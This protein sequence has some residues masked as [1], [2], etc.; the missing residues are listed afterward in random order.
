MVDQADTM[1]RVLELGLALREYPILGD[2]I[3]RRMR[4]EMF[5]RGVVQPEQFEQEVYQKAVATQHREGLG[6]PDAP[7]LEDVWQMRLARVRD[8]LTEFYFANNL[9]RSLF[10]AVVAGVL[11]ERNQKNVMLQ[12]NP[13]TAPPSMLLAQASAFEEADEETR[14]RTEHHR[15]EVIVV[16][17]KAMLSDQLAFVARAKD[18]LRVADLKEIHARRIGRGKVGGKAAGLRLAARILQTPSPDDEVDLSSRVVV[19][20]TWHI[21]AD[22][23]YEFIE[24]NDLYELFGQKY[25]PLEE[26]RADHE[27]NQARFAASRL[28]QELVRKLDHI[29]DQVGD[30]P[31]IARSSSLLE[32][33]FGTAFAGKYE[34]YFCPNQGTRADRLRGLCDAIRKVYASVLNPDALAY[35]KQMGLIDYDERMAILLQKVE[36]RVWRRL[37][38][39]QVAGVGFSRNP[40][41]WTPRIDRSAGFLRIVWG[42]GTRAVNRVERDHPRLVA[43]SHPTLRPERTAREIQ[44][45]SQHFVD[46]I[47]LDKNAFVSV[48]VEDA[49]GCD[50]PS[51][52][53]IA[54]VM[55][56]GELRR[57]LLADPRTPA[58]HYVVTFD[59]M[60]QDALFP[61]VMRAILR[62]LEHAYGVPVDIEFTVEILPGPV[63]DYR[64]HLLQCRPQARGKEDEHVHAPRD[65]PRGDLVFQSAHTVTS[66]R[67]SNIRHV[68]FVDPE[69]YSRI[70]SMHE[71]TRLARLIG[72]INERLAGSP[73]VLVGPGRWGS[74]NAELGVP[75]TYADIYNADALVEVP[76]SIQDEEPEASFG[77]H[78]FQDLVES[79]IKPVAVYPE[80]GDHFDFDFFRRAPNSLS[81]LLADT[82]GLDD[83]VRVIDVPACQRG[84]VLEMVLEAG[85]EELAVAFLTDAPG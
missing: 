38:F 50:Y 23:N 12:L 9:P 67:V 8:M 65:V 2:V 6:E 14:R 77:T 32:D 29:L 46:A 40:Y 5:R 42:L 37:F 21:A 15:K 75:V 80:K 48:P 39:P 34:T 68:V 64:V 20:E 70:P 16:L 3:R 10:Q 24:E 85:E 83:L 60:L 7:E 73:F 69:R 36:G 59:G 71:R 4:E 82:G 30:A 51:L 17:T 47:D 79:D 58:A 41:R 63:P 53:L 45:Y 28:P 33:S 78:F 72:R 61:A 62:K 27:A 57:I 54:S 31:L 84:R 43:L 44:R 66:G 76:M 35:R 52:R 18:H 49:V 11:G 74:T 26:A 81:S 13:E 55:E 1:E 19:P 22:M 56:D 25:K